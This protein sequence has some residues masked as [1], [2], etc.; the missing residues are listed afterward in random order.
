VI[1]RVVGLGEDGP[2]G[3]WFLVISQ[4][5]ICD[6]A[7]MLILPGVVNIRFGEEVTSEFLIG[8]QGLRRKWHFLQ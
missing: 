5:G 8:F 4:A 6:E 1:P 2:H 3:S 7:V